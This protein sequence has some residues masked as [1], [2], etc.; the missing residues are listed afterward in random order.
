M[1]QGR[2]RA[3]PPALGRS[4]A[5]GSGRQLLGAMLGA[6]MALLAVRRTY[7]TAL[8]G[9]RETARATRSA[10]GTAAVLA[11]GAGPQAAEAAVSDTGAAGSAVVVG[12]GPAGLAAAWVL[13]ARGFEVTVLERR[14]EPNPYE[15]QRAYLYLVDGRGQ[16]FTDMAGITEELAAP[17]VSVSNKDYTITRCFPDGKRVEVVPPILDPS[18]TR[19]SYWIPRAAFL[20]LLLR[21]LPERVRTLFGSEL[22]DLTRTA[23]GGVEVVAKTA[24]GEELRLHPQLVVGADGLNSRVREKCAEW[25]PDASGFTPV[26]LP[27]PS[28]GLRYKM[29]RLPPSFRLD[30]DDASVTASPRQAYVIRP[31]KRAPLGATRLGLLPVADPSFPRTANVI[32]PPEHPVW[33]LNSA[34]K[35][36]A[37][38]DDTFP[39][40]PMRDIVDEEEASAFAECRPGAFPAPC[41]APKQHL[42]LPKAGICLVGDA[43]HAFPPDIGQG[44]NAA[45]GDVMHLSRALDAALA[46]GTDGPEDLLGRALPAYE[47]ACA[48]EAEAV[49]RIAQ[50]GFPYQYP[51][52][53]EKNPLA[54]TAWFANFFLR[55]FVLAKALP[56]VFSPAAIVLVQRPHLSYA[57]IWQ[58]AKVTTRRLQA[59]GFAAL[60]LAAWPWLRLLLA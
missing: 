14:A 42:L 48:P 53:R 29:I 17:E 16:Q 23:E 22:V 13:A 4:P 47:A 35:V 19:P 11:A 44:V 9:G 25:S 38:L 34:E 32:L 52:T 10:R 55:T 39:A 6:A 27:S 36:R 21:S 37:W 46:A 1:Q 3:N 8:A 59:L 5:L 18:A 26:V 12:A 58:K 31:A 43:I 56:R 54:R 49:A 51:I 33:A 28:S 50:V 15:P 60:L 41:F 57:A 7:S 24:N 2:L 40:T 20:G 30:A 45:L